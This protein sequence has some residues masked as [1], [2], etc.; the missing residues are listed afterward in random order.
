MK[1]PLA[2]KRDDWVGNSHSAR[3]KIQIN[4]A[5]AGRAGSLVKTATLEKQ[6]AR[7][8]HA[9][10]FSSRGGKARSRLLGAGCSFPKP[11]TVF[12]P[13]YALKQLAL[14]FRPITLHHTFRLQLWT[15]MPAA[16]FHHGSPRQRNSTHSP[17]Q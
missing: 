14:L 13:A 11:I 10:R 2:E 12:R 17:T 9:V 6:I 5:T 3:E 1:G 4:Q 8:E 16:H 15:Q 7:N